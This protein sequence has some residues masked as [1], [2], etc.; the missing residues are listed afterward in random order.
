MSDIQPYNAL[1]SMERSLTDPGQLVDGRSEKDWMH[2]IAQFAG[3]VNFYDQHNRPLGNWEPFVLKDPVFLLASISKTNAGHL[4][5]SYRNTGL[6]VDRLLQ[7]DA[8]SPA[9]GE[10]FNRLFDSM[11]KAFLVIR[12]WVYYMQLSGEEYALK[13][14][15]V[16]QVK[17]VFSKYFQAII[18]LRQNLYLTAYIPGITPVDHDELYLFDAV[19]GMIW[20]EN[21]DKT[22]YWDVLGLKYPLKDNTAAEINTAL[23]KAG[24]ELFK[25]MNRVVQQASVEYEQLYD[26]TC[27]F[28]DTLLLR[29]F[30]NVMQVHRQQ[31]NQ[32]TGKHLNFC[33]RD[34]LK[35]SERPVEPD[36]V[37]LAATT[38][39]GDEVITIPQGTLFDGGVDEQ[40][41]PVSFVTT[42]EV[43]V[44][45][46]II[47]NVYTVAAIK[48]TDSRFRIY[49]DRIATPDKVQKTEDGQIKTWKTFGGTIS[50]ASVKMGQAISFASPLLLLREG[51]RHITI[52]LGFTTNFDE[53]WLQDVQYFLSTQT[54]WLP[55]AA[56]VVAAQ[57]GEAVISISLDAAQPPIEAF[58]KTAT[59][60]DPD[61]LPTVW[62]LFKIEFDSFSDP[63]Q[64][65][66][67]AAMKIAVT[68][69]GVK[70]IMAYN[71]FGALDIK[72][73]FQMFGPTPLQHSN[74]VI[75]SNEVFS[76]PL[77]MLQLEMTFDKLP[78]DFADYYKEY[79]LFIESRV[80]P[81]PSEKK[82][83]IKKIW[84]GITGAVS[85]AWLTIKGIFKKK[86]PT[87]EKKKMSLLP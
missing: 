50:P 85:K 73:P 46:A 28:P 11:V 61:G 15:T 19:D 7:R 1:R 40:K 22:P 75:G 21:R 37:F 45:P 3:L 47:S 41:N 13:N 59:L 42:E 49:R 57:T 18:S 72:A 63:A 71:D 38:A 84:S 10:S 30:I 78:E 80:K 26:K 36:T 32:L 39:T 8:A 23:N 31:M 9:V 17:M 33:Y 81:P 6:H 25:F 54:A 83:L 2:F 16:Q 34:I 56:T 64:P 74:F 66:V 24:S 20:K 29:T 43:D 62:P 82:S 35:F 14:Y 79:N 51:I 58:L 60:N 44:N 5:T 53:T 76:K 4:Y 86:E 12:R 65:P 55:V 77:D 70:N 67:L 27:R 48:G 69:Q 52:T 87:P 68:V